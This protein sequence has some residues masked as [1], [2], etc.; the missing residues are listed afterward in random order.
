MTNKIASKSSILL[1]AATLLMASCFEDKKAQD[2]TVSAGT[3][4]VEIIKEPLRDPIPPPV[5][6][7]H[8]QPDVIAEIRPPEFSLK[9]TFGIVITVFN[10]P[11]YLRETLASLKASDLR[12]AIVVIVDDCST[13]RETLSLLD[14][15]DLGETPLFKFSHRKNSGVLSGLLTGFKFLQRNV[16]YVLNIDS[17]VIMNSH[18]LN[19]LESTYQTINDPNIILTGFNTRSH[20]NIKC[21]QMW[22]EKASMGGLNFFMSSEFY[23]TRFSRWFDGQD[24]LDRKVWSNWDSSVG[25]EMRR[26]NFKLYATKPSVLQHI[27]FDGLNSGFWIGAD[28]ADDFVPDQPNFSSAK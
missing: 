11:K 21:S 4:R 6:A 26:H 25:Q 13:D 10:R 24:R 17:D 14:E 19:A 2:V 15:L 7:P 20:P 18:W 23:E 1:T 28:I 22:C 3:F 8:F 16:K 12:D 27:G 9:R 5:K